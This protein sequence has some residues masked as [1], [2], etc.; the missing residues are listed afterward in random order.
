M[1]QSPERRKPK[2][3]LS[4][5]WSRFVPAM[6]RRAVRKCQSG[7]KG[8][9][10]SGMDQQSNGR[11]DSGCRPF[12]SGQPQ[13][14]ACIMKED[15]PDAKTQSAM[16]SLSMSPGAKINVA[17]WLTDGTRL[18][19]AHDESL[20]KID[21]NEDSIQGICDK[22]ISNLEIYCQLPQ[23]YTDDTRILTYAF[24]H[25]RSLIISVS[26]VAIAA[27]TQLTSCRW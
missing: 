21:E 7:P 24:I 19:K 17:A 20:V 13:A 9:S 18:T 25:M 5:A 11:T 4:T 15:P 22:Q 23:I 2:I 16:K 1:S 10:K 26:T 6:Q 14:L 8:R 3:E 27:Q 12:K